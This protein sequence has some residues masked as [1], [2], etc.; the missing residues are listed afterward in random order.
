MTREMKSSNLMLSRR[1]FIKNKK[2]ANKT[3]IISS[4][5][6]SPSSKKN[7][8]SPYKRRVSENSNQTKNI[9][10][11]GRSIGVGMEV[12]S[13]TIDLHEDS[14]DDSVLLKLSSYRKHEVEK[15]QKILKQPQTP[16]K[17]QE[18]SKPNRFSTG[19]KSPTKTVPK[20]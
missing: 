2:S 4:K 1:V 11:S 15:F 7:A 12:K 8:D 5:V 10:K 14:E 6:E 17:I 3:Q 18:I 9:P 13:R 20:V 16:E 19:T